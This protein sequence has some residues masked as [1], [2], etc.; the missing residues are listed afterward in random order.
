MRHEKRIVWIMA[1]DAWCIKFEFIKENTQQI[2]NVVK[3]G[4]NIA[5]K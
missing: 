4:N 3:D 5:M 2:I 1:I